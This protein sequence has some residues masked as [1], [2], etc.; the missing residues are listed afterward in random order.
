MSELL[1]D[2][3][4]LRLS[5]QESKDGNPNKVVVRGTFA[6][7]DQP[8]ENKRL[9][10]EHLWKREFGRLAEG[11]KRR[12]VMGELDHPQDGRTKLQRVSHIITNL[13]VQGNEVV[14]EAE[15]LDTPNGRIMKA[16]A[17]AAG[18][19][20][21]S[22]RG[23]GSVKSR[24]D[25]VQEV[26]EDF[27][28]DTF[29]FVADPATKSAYPKVF[30][31]ERERI[32]EDEVELTLE[33]L[34]QD[35]PGLVEELVKETGGDPANLSEGAGDTTTATAIHEAEER[36]KT[37]LKEQFANELR[38]ST[39]VIREELEERI[40]ADLMSDPDIAQSKQVVEQIASLVMP[41]G[42]DQQAKQQ[43]Q[44]KDEEVEDLKKQLS[45]K[46]LEIQRLQRESKETEKVAKQAAYQL[47][48]E[49]SLAEDPS[50]DAIVALVGDVTE[51]SSRKEIDQKVEAVR[52]ELERRGGPD[53]EDQT[54]A[55]EER[56]QEM[57]SRLQES[58]ER[59][60]EAEMNLAEWERKARQSLRVAE[61]ERKNRI[62][63]EETAGLEEE[64]VA[65]IKDLVEDIED[66]DEVQK[67]IFEQKRKEL[68]EVDEGGGTVDDDT[69]EKIRAAA[70][71]GKERDLQEDTHG[72]RGVPGPNAGEGNGPL[73]EFGLDKTMYDKLAG[74]NKPS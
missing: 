3:M 16:I 25:G 17:E 73:A 65:R 57:E 58:E 36:T 27:R 68:V 66:P 43:M 19:V 62:I 7:S 51:Y 35:Y 40:R 2:S 37:R 15:V 34:K 10:R 13:E 67:A 71:R 6:R 20:G 61:R 46:E 31:E 38:R 69:A 42:L 60:K 63:A 49:R 1:I 29:D 28:L 47:H 72:N 50:K 70:A 21:V 39:E 45:D 22:S 9:Y 11:I 33:K 12:R 18:E 26:Q 56:F 59:A 44:E 5:L 23:F 55:W 41:F 14:G 30:R 64:Q 53:N 4:P 32:A 8:T 54:S 52:D 74:S 48:L 24:Q